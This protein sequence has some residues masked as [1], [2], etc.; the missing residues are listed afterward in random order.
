MPVMTFPCPNCGKP[1][2]FDY[3]DYDSRNFNNKSTYYYEEIECI[4]GKKLK[5]VPWVAVFD[6]DE[7]EAIHFV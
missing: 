6:E 2:G 7:E 1:M 4:C 5:T 3:A